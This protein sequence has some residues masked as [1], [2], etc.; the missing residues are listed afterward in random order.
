M[1]RTATGVLFD[2]YGTLLDV[3]LCEDS[4]PLWDGLAAAV[5][6]CGGVVAHPAELR[7][8]FQMIL[9]E[10]G[11][12]R[13]EGFLMEPTFSRLLA[14]FG[15]REEVAHVGRVF[16][17]LSLE[18]L[19]IRPYV[20]PLFARLRRA[21]CAVGIVSNTESVLTQFDLDCHPFLRSVDAMI[22]SS[23]VG[24]RKPQVEIFQIALTRLKLLAAATIFVGN[25]VADD[26]EGARRAGLRAV[27]LDETAPGVEPVPGDS[28][29]V[30]VT[31]TLDALTRALQL[32]G[33]RLSVPPP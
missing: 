21:C 9:K 14:S 20:A 33:C 4:P 18:A 17:Q 13:Q 12:R 32:L 23:E 3:R 31:P 26:I 10:E 27:Y 7:R 25:S 11:L 30:R 16:R 15:A 22:L 8:R 6:D 2:L 19:T 5:R 1:D 28:L 24:V 29:V